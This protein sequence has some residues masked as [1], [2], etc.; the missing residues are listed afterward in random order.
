MLVTELEFDPLPTIQSEADQA[1]LTR[2]PGLHLSRIYGDIEQQW[3]KRQPLDDRDRAAYMAGGFLWEHAF[4]KAFSQSLITSAVTRPPELYLDGIIGSPD[5]INYDRW[6]PWD[7]K[8]TWKSARKLDSMERHF[9]PWLVQQKGYIRMMQEMGACRDAELFIF[10]VNG[11]YAPP[12]PQVRHL[13]LEFEQVEIDENWEMV[14][15]HAR[16]RGWL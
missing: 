2:T 8:F 13:L 4:S 5:L 14:T 16:Y 3:L 9:W 1:G 15:R 12:I 6:C 11:D 7:T 10:F